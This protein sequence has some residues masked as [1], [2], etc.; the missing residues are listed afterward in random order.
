MARVRTSSAAPGGA[1]ADGAPARSRED[2]GAETRAR[3]LE[4]A[5]DVFGHEGFEGATTRKIARQ[6]DANLA[7]ILYH[8]GSKEA[9]YLAVAEHVIGEIAARLGQPLAG[10]RGRLVSGD[11]SRA[12]ARIMIRQLL[13]S[14][15][16][17]M[18][19]GGP[20]AARWARFIVREQLDPSPAFE[21]IY[22]V[23]GPT[24][25]LLTRLVALA[26]GDD[27][28]ELRTKVRAFTVLGQGLVFRV[29]E[30]LVLRRLGL[31]EIGE[32]ERKEIKQVIAANL[33]ALLAS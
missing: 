8:F 6:A 17:V 14:F 20:D 7:A 9:L 30:T 32:S 24:H 2:R 29:A 25:D 18:I 11:P 16:E 5:L 28:D 26:T 3:L 10:V 19:G 4:A 21:V 31:T 23:M 15:V 33:D 12:E 22:R 13:E 27:P 1:S